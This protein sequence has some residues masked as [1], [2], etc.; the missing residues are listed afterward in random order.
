MLTQKKGI[1]VA[2]TLATSYVGLMKQLMEIN[3]RHV[4]LV[5]KFPFSICHTNMHL[6][7]NKNSDIL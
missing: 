6:L 2:V 1:Y 3:D 4:L 7:Y 5:K